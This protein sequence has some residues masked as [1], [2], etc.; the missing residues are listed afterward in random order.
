MGNMACQGAMNNIIQEIGES[1]LP[2]D[3][4]GKLC[5]TL[6]M[7]ALFAQVAHLHMG[8]ANDPKAPNDGLHYFNVANVWSNY[9]INTI[10]DN[11]AD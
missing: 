3:H 2:L 5:R 6:N 11:A 4:G 9:L 10:V 1:L 7:N 8:H